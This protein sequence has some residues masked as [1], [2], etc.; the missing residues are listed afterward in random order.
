M[1]QMSLDQSLYTLYIY[2]RLLITIKAIL[3]MQK[4]YLQLAKTLVLK[5]KILK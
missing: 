4:D 5:P 3:W 2:T 1:Q